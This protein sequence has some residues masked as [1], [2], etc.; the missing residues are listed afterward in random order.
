MQGLVP[1]A[2]GRNVQARDAGVH[3]VQLFGLFFNR[4][5]RDQV[6]DALLDWFGRVEVGRF[7]GALREGEAAVEQDAKDGGKTIL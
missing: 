4:H 1:S 5:A 6:G 2:P 7:G 3:V